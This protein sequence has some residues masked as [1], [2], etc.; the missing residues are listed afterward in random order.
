MDTHEWQL[1]H[2]KNRLSEVINLA[3]SE[4]PQVITRHGEKTAVILSYAEYEKLCRTQG[5][6]SD[7]FRGSPLADMDVSRDHS[8]PREGLKS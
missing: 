5:K 1:Q 8:Q 2:A 4:G 3:M 6:L 7:F